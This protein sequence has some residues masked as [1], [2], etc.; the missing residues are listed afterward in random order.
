M[1]INVYILPLLSK[2]VMSFKRSPKFNI[3]SK[4]KGSQSIKVDVK[5]LLKFHGSKINFSRSSLHDMILF[6]NGF[7]GNRKQKVE[8]RLKY[9]LSTT[10]YANAGQGYY[11]AIHLSMQVTTMNIESIF[12]NFKC[13]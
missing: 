2:L 12:P 9:G 8:K 10:L 4:C 7:L 3:S 6:E 13:R 1:C 5:L 11:R